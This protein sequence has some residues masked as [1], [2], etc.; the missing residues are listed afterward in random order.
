MR[1]LSTNCQHGLFGSLHVPGDKSISHRSIIFGA[2]SHGDTRIDHFLASEDCLRTLRAF[3]NLGVSID[4]T[5]DQVVVHGKG[6]NGLTPPDQPL[7]MGNSGTTTRLMIGLLSGQ[8]FATQ[9]FG[10]DSLSR[11]P[12]ARV[13]DPLSQ[14]GARFT[15]TNDRLPLTVFGNRVLKP[16]H[17]SLP[18]ASAQVKSALI[19]AA[20]Q[21]EGWSTII[22]KQ[23]TRNHTE[24]ML[25]AFGGE[26]DKKGLTLRVKGHPALFGQ[27]I[28]VPGDMSSAAFFIAAAALLPS[29]QLTLK[30]IGL[31]P[32]RTGFLRVLQRMGAQI[33]AHQHTTIGE[34]A[35]D[36]LVHYAP[37]HAVRLTHID[38]PDCIDELPLLA[39][40][41]TQAQGTT[42]ITGAEELRVK[43]T[44]RI[45]VVAEELRK[46]GAMIEELPD[47]LVIQGPTVLTAPAH[48]RVDSHGDHRIGMMLAIAALLVK[49]SLHLDQ[50]SAVRIS[51]P[52]FFTDLDHLLAEG[53]RCDVQNTRR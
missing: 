9:L 28:S 37:L 52:E 17:Y 31:N 50:E 5:D 53:R 49:G 23:A 8:P 12:M 10:D 39:L 18:V 15:S 3:Q 24:I 20:L 2:I 46:L 38:I 42:T 4:Y 6:L 40:L 14:I 13:I 1:E 19:L 21:T 34:P 27:T 11:R 7:N 41:A 47:G 33:I 25:Q 30:N 32:T 43:E 51:Y 45:A 16:L 48:H 26:L 29:S 36:L 44:D 22:E 35:G